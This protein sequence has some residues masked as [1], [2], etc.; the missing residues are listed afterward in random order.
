MTAAVSET[1]LRPRRAKSQWPVAL[2][3]LAPAMVG[4]RDLLLPA[5]RAR[6]LQQL[7]RQGAAAEGVRLDRVAELPRHARRRRLLQ[8]VEGHA[9]L[10]RRQHRV[11]DDLRGRDRLDPRQALGLA[12][13]AHR[14][15]DAVPDVERG[16]RAAV[17][18]D[19]RLPARCRQRLPRVGR[20]RRQAVPQLA[21]VGD[22][23][24]RDDQRLAPHGLHGAA[25]VRRPA[26]DPERREGG[27]AHRRVRRDPAVLPRHAAAAAARARGG[28]GDHRDR[29]VPDLRHR[30]RHDRGRAGQ[31]EPGDLRLHLRPGLRPQQ[32]RL[33]LGAVGRAVPDP[34]RRHRRSRCGSSARTNRTWHERPRP[35]T[36]PMRAPTTD[37]HEAAQEDQAG[38]RGAR[39]GGDDPAGRHAV[40]LLLVAAHRVL[41][42]LRVAVELDQVAAGELHAQRV[43][44]G[45]RLSPAPRSRSRPAAPAPRSTSSAPS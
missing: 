5:D 32:L 4:L 14:R 28:A 1:P 11:P 41:D 22:P 15:D 3:F 26:D 33:R 2:V 12:P 40:P 21:G 27:R 29:L 24:D 36:A 43:R 38:R 17:P 44:A 23:V 42:E 25:A 9:L 45:A 6:L 8:R 13:H 10:R 30:R 39:G 19:P 34:R 7:H 16:G 35:S 37:V 31:C 20:H 18:L